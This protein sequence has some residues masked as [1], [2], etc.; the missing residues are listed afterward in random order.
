ME[1]LLIELNKESETPLY[2]QIYQ[3]NPQRHYRRQTRCRRKAS[4]QTETR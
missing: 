1:M 3:A 2:E 4:I